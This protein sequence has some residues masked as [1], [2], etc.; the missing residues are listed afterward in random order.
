MCC[1]RLRLSVLQLLIMELQLELPVMLDAGIAADEDEGAQ[2]TLLNLIDDRYDNLRA[3][4]RV[5]GH[6]CLN[7]VAR[8]LYEAAVYAAAARRCASEAAPS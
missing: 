2:C 7:H 8:V 3:F 4:L 1:G 6:A 5:G